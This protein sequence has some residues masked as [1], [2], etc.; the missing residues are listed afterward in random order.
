MLVIFEDL[1][2]QFQAERAK[3]EAR[4]REL[5]D[6]N[7]ARHDAARRERKATERQAEADRSLDCGGVA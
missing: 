2:V 3:D 1:R 7:I 6:E 5:F 4:F